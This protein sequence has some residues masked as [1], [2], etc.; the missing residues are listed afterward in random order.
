MDYLKHEENIGIHSY[1][2]KNKPI[3]TLKSIKFNN[4]NVVFLVK[5][6]IEAKEC[7]YHEEIETV[8]NGKKGIKTIEGRGVAS[9]KNY[10]IE[11]HD[12]MIGSISKVYL[13]D[14]IRNGHEIIPV[15]YE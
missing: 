15:I 8:I 4:T 11:T 6:T 12:V 2:Y 5:E 9:S 1:F 14:L 7:T 3:K 10:Y 13:N